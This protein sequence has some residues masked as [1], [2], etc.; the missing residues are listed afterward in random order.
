MEYPDF[1]NSP[2]TPER[3]N[4]CVN[5]ESQPHN[6]GL[7]NPLYI[8]IRPNPRKMYSSHNMNTGSQSKNKKENG[9]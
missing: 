1:L 8:N 2:A 3:Y 9:S 5:S 6:V 7:M 4:H